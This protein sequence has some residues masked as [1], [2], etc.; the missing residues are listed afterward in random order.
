MQSTR[1][2]DRREANRRETEQV[3]GFHQMLALVASN[4]VGPGGAAVIPQSSD[5]LA[6]DGGGRREQRLSR[7]RADDYRNRMAGGSR[8]S[9]ATSESADAARAEQ[10]R[11]SSSG[12]PRAE[13]KTDGDSRVP[14]SAD[15]KTSTALRNGSDASRKG[16]VEA[17]AKAESL[18][19][20]AVSENRNDGGREVRNAGLKQAKQVSVESPPGAAQTPSGRG[21]HH[22]AVEQSNRVPDVRTASVRPRGGEAQAG[23]VEAAASR[24][25]PES[26][27]RT[28][29][30][31]P[32]AA[33][34]R[35]RDASTTGSPNPFERVA[36]VIRAR[37][38]S[39]ETVA[40]IRLDP[41]E[42][43][44]VRVRM[45]MNNNVIRVRLTAETPDARRVLSQR[46][47]ELLSSLEQQGLRVQRL[48]FVS[49]AR[50]GE[51]PV[52][53][54][55]DQ[56]GASNS[57][58][59]QQGD[60]EGYDRDERLPEAHGDGREAILGSLDDGLGDEEEVAIDAILD[61]RI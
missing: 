57:F 19:S 3:G 17:G 48:E 29:Q 6:S 15:D 40:H 41:P 60:T 32:A 7:M 18:P 58:G 51:A 11:A 20:R 13:G 2:S 30:P 1:P 9:G 55:P 10:A 23:R 46:G 53:R 25:K 39:S 54:Q 35:A 28:E 43:G 45:R 21:N 49:P 33:I 27:V 8:I 5:G 44:R 16:V 24:S 37:S 14:R 31:R 47:D 61:I 26:V 59:A 22:R 36:R 50:D 34:R 4:A 38:G 52:G 56:G 12:E 42:L